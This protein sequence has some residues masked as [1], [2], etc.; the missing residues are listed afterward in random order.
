MHGNTLRPIA[1][2][3]GGLLFAA[4]GLAQSFSAHWKS[5]MEVEGGPQQSPGPVSA[6]IWLKQGKMLM[7][8]SVMGMTMNIVKSGDMVYQWPEGQK[9]GM[10][11]SAAASP[12]PQ[13]GD[14]V[15]RIEEYRTRGKK[16]GAEKIHGHPCEIYELTTPGAG[17]RGDERKET[18]WLATDLHN[19][20]IKVITESGGTKV[21]SHNTDIEW[22]AAVADAMVTPPTDVEF[23]DMSEMMKERRPPPQ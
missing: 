5:A 22:N 11:M 23:Q 12:R 14:Y 19:F 2:V 15:N 3:L 17:A 21:T 7:K 10:K 9:T 18:V 16:V 6:E 13:G 1:A 8:T 4:V 20:P